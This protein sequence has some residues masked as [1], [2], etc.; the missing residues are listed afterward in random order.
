M[1]KK[2]NNFHEKFYRDSKK[3]KKKPSIASIGNHGNEKLNNS[4][5]KLNGKHHQWNTRWGRGRMSVFEKNAGESFHSYINE[6]K[7]QPSRTSG[8]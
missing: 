3:K 1:D 7:N 8:T 5:K 6:G 4:N 2:Y